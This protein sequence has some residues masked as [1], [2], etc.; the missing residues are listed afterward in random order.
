MFITFSESVLLIFLLGSTH[1]LMSMLTMLNLYFVLSNIC[2]PTPFVLSAPAV[3]KFSNLIFSI[4]KCFYRSRRNFLKFE[5]FS[6]IP[7]FN[8]FEF[9]YHV[10]RKLT[11]TWF[12]TE[13][14]DHIIRHIPTMKKTC[15]GPEKINQ[16]NQFAL[17]FT[18]FTKPFQYKI[19]LLKI[20]VYLQV[21]FIWL[22]FQFCSSNWLALSSSI[23][24]FP[25]FLSDFVVKSKSPYPFI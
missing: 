11:N 19:F 16:S 2:F 15:L 7:S 8:E 9:P 18:S 10:W 24:Y 14:L 21:Q 23:N 17:T 12:H 5:I 3:H 6:L 4:A 25:I 20:Y 22:Y 1:Q 13:F